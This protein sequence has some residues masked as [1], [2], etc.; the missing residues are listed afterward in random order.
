MALTNFNNPDNKDG[1]VIGAVQ[2]LTLY[3]FDVIAG[4]TDLVIASYPAPADLIVHSI[5]LLNRAL[6]GGVPTGGLYNSTAAAN[7]VANGAFG[8]T[9]VPS[10]ELVPATANVVVAKNAVMQFRVTT[11]GGVTI[12]GAQIVIT[13]QTT[14]A[15]TGRTL[16]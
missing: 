14:G 3:G 15:P 8:A 4:Q 9:T 7:I 16:L 10:A 13:F 1:G 12:T 2:T 6:A 5:R 11:G